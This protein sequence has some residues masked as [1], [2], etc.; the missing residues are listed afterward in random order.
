MPSYV[1]PKKNT[2]FIFY[3]FLVDTANRPSFKANPTLAAGDVKVSTDGGAFANLS[4]LP[5]V[6]PAAGVAVKV[7]LSASEMNGD[8][9][10]VTFKDAAGG[11]W[12]EVA[13]G[14]Q[15]S[16]RQI[17]DLAIPGSEMAL[18]NDAITA[19][20]IAANAIGAS[21]IADDAIT[22]AKI[23]TGAIDADAIADNAIDAGAIANDAI[24]AAKIATGAID[25]DAIADNAIDAGAI[26]ADAITAAKIATGAIDADAIAADAITA[27]KI[28][29][30]AIDAATFNADTD[31]YQAKVWL[32]DDDTGTADRYTVIWYKNGQPIVSGITSP[33]IQVYKIADGSD[34]VAS[35]AMTEIASTGTYRYV[36]ASNRIVDGVGYIILVS[37]TIGGSGRTWYQPVSRDS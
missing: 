19:A 37:A 8:N 30:G 24:T 33:T 13:F 18:I 16:A 20:K 25:A 27:A 9:I 15:T 14:I 31:T 5:A 17:D 4:T 2:E 26:A 22:A 6:T 12:D 28:A 7:T 3:A 10:V 32:T 29:N 11:E 35:T 36:E 21:E 23:A 34:L 1:T